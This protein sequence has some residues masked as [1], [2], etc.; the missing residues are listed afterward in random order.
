MPTQIFVVNGDPQ[1]FSVKIEDSGDAT[2]HAQID[3]EWKRFNR[4]DPATQQ[5][6]NIWYRLTKRG[7]SVK[8][9]RLMPPDSP[10]GP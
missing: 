8:V 4:V 2:K 1:L 10:A 7:Q 5:T 9:D 6:Y 3:A